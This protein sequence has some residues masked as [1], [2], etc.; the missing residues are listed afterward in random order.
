M[1]AAAPRRPKGRRCAGRRRD[2]SHPRHGGGEGRLRSRR[3]RRTQAAA[4]CL[5]ARSQGGYTSRH[6]GWRTGER[7][8]GGGAEEDRLRGPFGPRQGAS[9][10]ARCGLPPC[11]GIGAG[12]IVT[13]YMLPVEPMTRAAIA[14]RSTTPRR[15]AQARPGRARH[16]PRTRRGRTASRATVPTAPARSDRRRPQPARIPSASS[17]GHAAASIGKRRDGCADRVEVE[18]AEPVVGASA[19]T[20]SASSRFDSSS[21][22]I[23]S[24]RVPVQRG[25]R[26]G[27]ACLPEPVR[28]VGRLVLD[29]RVPPAV[30]VDDVVRRRQVQPSSRPPGARR[31]ERSAR[32]RPRTRRE[33][34]APC[35]T[36]AVEEPPRGRD[37]PARCGAAQLGY[38]VKTS[39]SV[40]REGL[41]LRSS[42][43]SLPDLPFERAPVGSTTSGWLQTC[44]SCP[45]NGEHRAAPVDRL[46]VLLDPRHQRSTVAR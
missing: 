33:L 8:I 4:T 19:I 28:A 6:P 11:G 45:S 29:R 36:R 43:S 24:S 3:R 5:Q 44:L 26:P 39:A 10:P 34:V 20:W 22:S 32:R 18:L 27:P 2:G 40:A 7:S 42:R 30:E 13:A 1:A 46:L 37:G 14:P 17:R 25:S 31:P 12:S 16:V 9:A 15:P 41:E 23:R 35:A 38:C 21:A